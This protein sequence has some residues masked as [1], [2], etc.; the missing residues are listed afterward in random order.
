VIDLLVRVAVNGVALIAASRIVPGISLKIG[1]FGPDWIKIAA[2]VIIFGLINTYLRPIVKALSLPITFLTMG[3]TGLVINAGAVLLLAFLS[4]ALS[5]PFT[6]AKFPPTFNADA[7]VAALLAGVLI[8]IVATV[9]T[10]VF[11][12]RKVFG[13]L[14]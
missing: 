9:L 7:F 2:V 11:G 6:V 10:L 8:S 12:T 3:A 13:I 1:P 4:K 5:L 14:I